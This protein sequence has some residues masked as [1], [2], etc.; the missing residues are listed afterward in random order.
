MPVAD[1]LMGS[2]VN[3]FP[4]FQGLI[5]HRGSSIGGTSSSTASLTFVIYALQKYLLYHIAR[6][7]HSLET[8]PERR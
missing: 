1:D 6:Y 8:D 2:A 3:A 5:D 7:G 4:D